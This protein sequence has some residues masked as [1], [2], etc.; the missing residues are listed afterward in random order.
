L[1]KDLLNREIKKIKDKLEAKEIVLDI[2]KKTKDKRL[3]ILNKY[4]PY[5][6]AISDMP[7]VF[8]VIYPDLI[9]DNWCLE[10]IKEND[11]NFKSKILM[12]KDWAGKRDHE[13]EIATGVN[14]S[15]FCHVGRFF[16]V[17]KTK[18]SAIELA[19][20]VLKEAGK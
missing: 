10:A 19:Q 4:Y 5:D 3:L 17:S 2:Y 18:E 14:G 12:P 16:A 13:L 11:V 8:L 20:I 7:D 9:D 6:I 1:S 15:V